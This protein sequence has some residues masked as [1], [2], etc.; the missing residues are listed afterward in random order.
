MLPRCAAPRVR[1]IFGWSREGLSAR[2]IAQRLNTRG[3]P[4][5]AAG[6]GRYYRDETRRSRGGS[7]TTAGGSTARSR[8]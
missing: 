4:S 1:L 3:V 2:S 7:R 5:P 8:R 6:S